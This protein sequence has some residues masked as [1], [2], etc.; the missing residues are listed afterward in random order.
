M[1]SRAGL[2]S[3]RHRF[4]QILPRTAAV[5]KLVSQLSELSELSL[6]SAGGVDID[7][8]LKPKIDPSPEKFP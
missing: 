1:R 2:L 7:R 4:L 5:P 6:L 8:N 3:I